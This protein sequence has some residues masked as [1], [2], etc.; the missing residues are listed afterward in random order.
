VA[1]YIRLQAL[2]GVFGT[3]ND[4][5]I[6]LSCPQNRTARRVGSKT[7]LRFGKSNIGHS[8]ASGG[9]RKLA[10]LVRHGRC[11]QSLD[12]LKLGPAGAGR[13]QAR[14]DLLYACAPFGAVSRSRITSD[15]RPPAISTRPA[16]IF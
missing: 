10:S 16:H 1:S 9:A 2:K 12:G 6:A 7:R 4:H 15:P 8:V 5:S 13:D 11:D 14:K 3:K